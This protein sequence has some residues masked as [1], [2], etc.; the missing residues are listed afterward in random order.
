[1]RPEENAAV[2]YYALLELESTGCTA[3][4]VKKAYRKLALLYHPDK[5][6][7]QL[8]FAE[9]FKAIVEANDILGDPVKRQIYDRAR[10][11]ALPRSTYGTQY[12]HYY[13]EMPTYTSTSTPKG[14]WAWNNSQRERYGWSNTPTSGSYYT[15]GRQK[16]T[17]S[18]AS[19]KPQTSRSFSNQ[20]GESSRKQS[21]YENRNRNA[22]P[23]PSTQNNSHNYNNK[24]NA[25]AKQANNF[26]FPRAPT[27]AKSA[28][29]SPKTSTEQNSPKPPR[30]WSSS[31]T[32]Y[33]MRTGERTYAPSPQKGAANAT[34]SEPKPDP[35]MPA[36]KRAE[37]NYPEEPSSSS[38]SSSP[39]STPTS[40]E[41]FKNFNG[42]TSAKLNG[43]QST[44]SGLKF[45]SP[46]FD[47]SDRPTA[48]PKVFT[49]A[50]PTSFNFGVRSKTFSDSWTKGTKVN[51]TGS[52]SSPTPSPRG[53]KDDPVDVDSDE[54]VYMYP[55]STIPKPFK[56]KI[57]RSSDADESNVGSK[58]DDKTIPKNRFV[59]DM[60]SNAFAKENP[61]L[62]DSPSVWNHSKIPTSVRRTKLRPTATDT[63]PASPESR[64]P[65]VKEEDGISESQGP[66]PVGTEAPRPPSEGSSRESTSESKPMS[67]PSPKKRDRHRLKS[68][69]KSRAPLGTSSFD[70]L[71]LFKTVPPFTQGYGE[72]KMD[73]LRKT[74]PINPEHAE[75]V[76]ATKTTS[77][78]SD[79][80]MDSPRSPA[81]PNSPKTP[82]A[83]S[84]DFANVTS[85]PLPFDRDAPIFTTSQQQP[86]P[87]PMD[88]HDSRAVFD[89]EPP[90][91]PVPPINTIN[92]TET[93]LLDYWQ[94][95]LVYQQQWNDYELKMTLYVNERHH[96][97]SQNSLQILSN[98][99]NLDRYI[100]ALQQD[101]RVR[102]KWNE[103]LNIHKR[104]MINLLAVRRIAEGW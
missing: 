3:E 11:K 58:D 28:T 65:T 34:F 44:G 27:A 38:G 25:K 52:Y 12:T 61:F 36:P 2:N 51:D 60:W 91:A 68:A 82:P 10:Q 71:G 89:I 50:T 62:F 6:Q 24:N 41:E 30:S 67:T 88:Y 85:Q 9:K 97:D 57:N 43:Q 96:A 48:K 54:D 86:A 39:T 75:P 22:N 8:E 55:D 20:D 59:A 95:V 32:A 76:T 5:N 56:E 18:T 103:A 26:S 17:S 63:K 23:G 74:Y 102:A 66:K 1:M 83:T 99:G 21:A 29:D 80:P 93:E 78:E 19:G 42:Q 100:K 46:K 73:D 79:I 4:E 84:A 94:R 14:T 70:D 77:V 101:D 47:F 64:Q 31:R 40:A 16:S 98:S 7:G 37:T 49:A 92:P 45:S 13:T 15:Y 35:E 104:V 33:S 87:T 90:S 53:S 72:F 81:E 69:M